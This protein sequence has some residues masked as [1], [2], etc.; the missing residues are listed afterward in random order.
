MTSFGLLWIFHLKK[1]QSDSF[2]QDNIMAYID[3]PHNKKLKRCVDPDA[4]TDESNV[5]D[6]LFVNRTNLFCLV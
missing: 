1:I 3:T 4:R 6:E 5:K 2:S